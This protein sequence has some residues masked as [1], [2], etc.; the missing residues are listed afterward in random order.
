MQ[1]GTHIRQF[2]GAVC[3]RAGSKSSR[4]TA[5]CEGNSAIQLN[6]QLYK[7]G[8]LGYHVGFTLQ[9][10]QISKLWL[11]CWGRPITH[12]QSVGGASGCCEWEMLTKH[13]ASH[14]AKLYLES[15]REVPKSAG[16]V[17]GWVWNTKLGESIIPPN[18]QVLA[19]HTCKSGRHVATI[20]SA[21]S[22][23]LASRERSSVP[24]CN[25]QV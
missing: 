8:K 1:V 13:M 4:R 15:C 20:H 5:R 18:L 14:R 19:Q 23:S 9:C 25:S 12:D 3:E 2:I 22:I 11:F 10:C 7:A 21:Y 24:L 6:G 17:T 16:P